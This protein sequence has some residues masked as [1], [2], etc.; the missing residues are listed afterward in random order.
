MYID[1]V[2]GSAFGPLR[3]ETLELAPG[4]NVVHGPNEAGK[5]SWFNATYAG[6][7]GRRK[8][9][10]KGTAAEAEFKS[11]HKPW[12]G[13]RWDVAI[14]LTLEDGRTLA[15]EQDL[16]K[17]GWTI[18][19][20]STGQS[21]PDTDWITDASLDGTR[22]LGLNR[23]S[24]RATIFTGQ[25]DI[26]RVLSDAGELQEL[27][28]R[29]ASTEAADATAE[30]ALSSLEE[31][32]REW[33]GTSRTANRPL[34]TAP[35]ALRAAQQSAQTRRDELSEL[36]EAIG[37]RQRLGTALER[38]REEA[39]LADRL[40]RWKAVYELRS[41]V[42]KAVA[43]STRLAGACEADL[44][45]DEEKVEGAL[46]ILG[47]FDNGT[48]GG[49]LPEGPSAVDLQAQIDA[50]PQRPE[51]DLEPRAEIRDVHTSLIQARTALDTHMQTS[52]REVELPMR[53]TLSADELRTLAD[54]FASSPPEV[55]T[56]AVVEFQRTKS[57]STSQ[58]EALRRDADGSE[59]AYRQA[60][61]DYDATV[62]RGGPPHELAELHN[63]ERQRAEDLIAATR[64]QSDYLREVLSTQEF[65]AGVMAQEV[66][67]RQYQDGINA[68]R[69]QVLAESLE[70]NPE[71]L[72][73]LAKAIDETVAAQERAREHAERAALLRSLRDDHARALAGLLDLSVSTE[74]S[75]D[76]VAQTLQGFIDYV[77]A[78]KE[79]AETA[80]EAGYR[81]YL[82][83]ALT[84]RQ[85]LESE[86]RKALAA[87]ESRGRAVAE[88]AADLGLPAEPLAVAA[89]ELRLWVGEQK[90]KGAALTDRH[91]DV[92]LLDQL[93][94]GRELAE[95]EAERATLEEQAGDEPE[96]RMPADLDMFRTAAEDRHTQAIDR[97]GQLKGKI[98]TL[99]NELGS[100]AEVVEREAD[101]ER[102]A[103]QVKTLASCFDTAI[104]ELQRAK[105]QANASIA[106]ALANRMR[107][108]LPRVT[109]G[110]YLDV[111][112]DSSD[113]TMRVTEAAGQLRQ[114]DRLSLG[115]TE[116]L[117]L[118]LRVTLSQVLSGSTETAPLIFDDVTTQSDTA[119]T[120]AMLELLHE[121]S[122]EHQV[123][124][125]TQEDEVVTWAHEH[126]DPDRD[127]I[128][129]LPAP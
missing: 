68:A 86:H 57:E 24:A 95:L 90:A 30:G 106:P 102:V 101:A 2:A 42:D 64:R 126:I 56:A 18:L 12:S 121:L 124:L 81:G 94:S 125:F 39:E 61:A 35:A 45:V 13:S 63:A 5:S 34:Q 22:L 16:A 80:H 108:W 26:L 65:Q 66:A 82:V 110:R 23:H 14:A 96:I 52:P 107:P 47:A 51:G 41:R 97:D 78:C 9:K 62:L 116:Q 122:T 73:R 21:I 8:I 120:V 17:G 100:V 127:K 33:V 29:A 71:A 114:A 44:V 19:D 87:R 123:I 83:E 53:P 118:L 128:I 70:P 113:L 36:L 28:E 1:K 105:D 129:L 40:F 49:P 48:E 60:K 109:N 4:F 43:L 85:H 72:K 7:A 77:A 11:R 74:I 37:N 111:T 103:T 89:D 117:Y 50:L 27:L 10:G 92:A 46:K 115:T 91:T 6:L 112:V 55:D 15:I 88:F 119:R 104:A 31:W 99:G 93:L 58:I 25:A 3:G 59:G 76:V 69:E 38:T 20:G 75:D 98:Q 54:I 79:R 84:Q 32:R 67:L